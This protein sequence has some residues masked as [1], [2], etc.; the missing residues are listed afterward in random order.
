M[1]DAPRRVPSNS[2]SIWRIAA[3]LAVLAGLV[4]MGT[5]LVPVYVH[6]LELERFVR[7]RPAAPDDAL[8]Q[9]ILDKGRSLGLNVVPDH[10]EIRHLPAGGPTGVRYVVRV[11]FP[12]Y[13]VDLHFASTVEGTAT[14]LREADTPR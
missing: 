6:N 3:G 14:R 5:L 12:L 10:V 8:K 7:A 9:A 13:S 2:I 1:S 11:T 4:G